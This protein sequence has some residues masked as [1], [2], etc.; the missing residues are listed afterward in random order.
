VQATYIGYPNTT[1]VP[2]I[3]YRIVDGITDPPGAE[4]LATEKLVRLD[5]CFLCYA[6]PEQA[7]AV[8]PPPRDANGFVTF[9]S[10]NAIKKFAPGMIAL[11]A[12]LLHEV[13]NSRLVIKSGGLSGRTAREHLSGLLKREGIPEVRFELLEKFDS[14][15]EHL[16]AYGGI[17]IALDTSPYNGTTTTCEALWMGVPVVSLATRLH[18][19]RVGDS[20]LTAVGLTAL[21]AKSAEEYIAIA[22]GLADDP[23]RTAELRRTM[24]ERVRTSPLCDAKAFAVKFEREM[25]EMWSV[26]CAGPR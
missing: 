1:G 9:G 5:G 17:D 19:G 14:K 2:T 13:P 22:K 4:A 16:A 7:P 21:V 18:A 24:R 15:Q 11:W 10:F 20:L 25:R 3:D 26:W 23:A 12:R 6:P 8:A